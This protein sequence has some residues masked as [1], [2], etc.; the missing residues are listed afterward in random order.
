ME[1]AEFTPSFN[2]FNIYKDILIIQDSKELSWLTSRVESISPKI[3]V[4]IG[5]ER[6]GTL[7]IWESIACKHSG[8]LVIGV[9]ITKAHVDPRIQYSDSVQ[10]VIG[11]SHDASVINEVKAILNGRQIDFLFI[12]GDHS[13][14]GVEQDWREFS[15][16]VKPG[17]LIGFHDIQCCPEVKSFFGSLPGKRESMVVSIGTGLITK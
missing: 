15:Q 14:Q 8:A 9:D 5:I 3:I 13:P 6:G 4:E 2:G 16:L 10:F 11:S 1:Q 12:D 7:K 17:G